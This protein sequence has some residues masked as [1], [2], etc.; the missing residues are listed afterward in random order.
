MSDSQAQFIEVDALRVGMY[1]YLDL[2]W[3]GH[4]FALNNFKII[5]TS[6]IDT[7]RSL[8]VQRLRWSPERSDL[9]LPTSSPQSVAEIAAD[10]KSAAV[11]DRRQRLLDQRAMLQHCEREFSNATQT[12]RLLLKQVQQQPTVAGEL[13]EEMVS[14]LVG[15]LFEQSESF[16]RLLSE[17]AGEH[18]SLHTI[19]VTVIALLLGKRLG[20]D[21]AALKPLGLGALLHDIGK[22]ALPERLRWRD[23]GLTSAEHRLFQQHALYG[24]EM[25]TRMGLD[26]AVCAIIAQHHEYMDGSG[27]P[28]QLAGDALSPASRI[29][30]LVNHYDNLCNPTNPVTA[31][32]PHKVLA[33]M[34]AHN[35]HKFDSNYLGVFI[36]M[37]GVYPPGSLV[38]LTDNRY[39]LVVSV[40][41]ARPLKPRVLIYDPQ[42]PSEDALIVDLEMESTLGIR[43]SL[44]PLQLPRAVFDYLSP[45]Q[46]LCYFFE[47][48]RDLVDAQEAR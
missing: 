18:A 25:A 28:E 35:Q 45:G 41:S 42:L 29:L 4:P 13:A 22:I 14:G 38:L 36:R 7:I 40:N 39:A 44:K 15:N 47:R 30:S 46:R 2:G 17:K 23:K 48:A 20:L 33:L 3:I 1:I 12:F 26:D 19:N 32:T 9:E 24:A 43:L 6:Q 31:M 37:M 27:F 21:A 34:F 11:A 16:I 5:S 10:A 8:G